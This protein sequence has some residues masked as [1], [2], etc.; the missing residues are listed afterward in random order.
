MIKI[1]SYN[2]NGIRAAIRKGFV[3]WLEDCNP[4]IIC[5]QETKANIDQFD[6]SVFK[7]LGYNDYWFSAEKKGYSGVGILTKLKPNK[8]HYG[9]GI[10]YM[11]R[12]GRNLMLD[13]DNFSI[14]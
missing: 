4:D 9:V 12:E 1:L 2:I 7:K 14:I 3:E 5:L 10:D 11:D 8:I 6:Q 13:F